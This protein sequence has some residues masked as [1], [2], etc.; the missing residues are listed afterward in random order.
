MEKKF[1]RDLFEFESWQLKK[2]NILCDNG[3]T[4]VNFSYK[5]FE[6]NHCLLI[7]YIHYLNNLTKEEM[8]MIFPLYHKVIENEIETFNIYSIENLIEENIIECKII[9]KND[10]LCNCIILIFFFQFIF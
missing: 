1:Y 5:F 6:I 4:K 9:S 7:K 3:L 8:S 10:I 2:K